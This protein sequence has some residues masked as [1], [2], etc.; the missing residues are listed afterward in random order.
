MRLLPGLML[1]VLVLAAAPPVFRLPG[2]AHP[3]RYELEATIVPRLGEFRGTVR[4]GVVFD[5]PSSELWLNSKDLTIDRASAGGHVAQA[6]VA[7][8]E[9][10]HLRF[11]ETLP[12]GLA[13]VSIDYHGALSDKANSGIY[14]KKSGT[15]WYAFTTF[16][17]I[18]ARR[19]FPCFDEPAYKTPW[20]VI[21]HI[22]DED[23]AASNSPLVS[24]RGEGGGL[25]R[26]EFEETPPLATE[27]VAFT[28]GPFDVVDAGVAGVNRVPVRVLVPRG[29]ASEAGAAKRAGA[30]LVEQLEQ[31]TGVPYPW[32]KLD[33]VAVL[34]MP[35][36]AVENPGLITYRDRGL[37]SSREQA[38]RGTMAHELAHQWF[39]N[40]V[41]QRWWDDVWLSEGFATWLGGKV[42]GGV[43]EAVASRERIMQADESPKTRPVRLEM[44]S[45]QDMERVYGRIVYQK[46]AAIL[47]MVEHWVG[48]EA[49]RRGLHAYLK[50]HAFGSATTRDLEEAIAEYS[51]KDVAPVFESFLNQTGYPVVKA[52][53]ACGG[54]GAKVRVEAGGWTV[55]VCVRGDGGVSQCVVVRNSGEIAA[56]PSCPK[57]V[58][59]NRD[60]SG[61]YRVALT[62]EQMQAVVG[63]G[64]TQLNPSEQ[65][66]VANEL[67]R[68]S[69]K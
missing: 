8:G 33:H 40:L 69:Q 2:T 52:T 3:T 59:P 58:W 44:N 7:A 67:V 49:F 43:A 34:D 31:Y 17:A 29:R 60:G 68:T 55:P 39:G 11:P 63:K 4:I 37:L 65:L 42:S 5:Q 25:K 35:Y 66:D 62:P 64:W 15:D 23:F 46:G 57:W 1:P 9:F 12:A 13:R 56:G 22:P 45:R 53:V 28:V 10:V 47:S 32:K 54:D 21:L 24:E 48:E 61:Y 19:A 26:V 50:E 18:E 30:G 41:T 51:G 38:I 6:A 27:V 16:T 20:R 36:G 14:R